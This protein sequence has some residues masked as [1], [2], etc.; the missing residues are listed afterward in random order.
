M[1][2]GRG[3]RKQI[4]PAEELAQLAFESVLDEQGVRV[5][6]FVSVLAAATGEAVIVSAGLFDIEDN[7][8]TPGTPVFGDVINTLLSADVTDVADVAGSTSVVGVLIDELVPATVPLSAFDVLDE[9]YGQVAAATGSLEFGEVPIT[10][11]PDNRPFQPPLRYAVEFRGAVDHV[12]SQH[13]VPDAE[14]YK[15]CAA[16]LADAIR[17][18]S[19]AIDPQ[20]AVRLALDVIFGVAKLVPVPRER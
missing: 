2:F 5:E 3:K 4:P 11:D 18:T 10:V 14:R 12:A 17:Q 7:D 20:I 8:M 15:L 19:G 1:V 6:E 16:A 9:L 13:A